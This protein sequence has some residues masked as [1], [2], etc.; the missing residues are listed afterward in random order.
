MSILRPVVYDGFAQRQLA[1]GDIL[2]GGETI[3]ATVVT[4]AITVTGAQLQQGIILRNPAAA[5]TD[6]LD[7]AANIIA[8]LS[9]GLGLGAIPNGLT[10]RVRWIVT[11]AQATTVQATANTGVTV[12]RGSIAASSAKEFLFTIVNGTPAQTFQCTTVN[13][14]NVLSGLTATQCSLLSVGMVIT[15]AVAGLQGQTIIAINGAAGTVTLSGNA[16]A[17]NSSPVTV[18]FSPVVQLDGLQ[19]GGI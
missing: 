12:N 4:T 7:T 1:Q 8:A 3:P 11:T 13:A 10:W 2:G 18:A 14:N 19:Q 15:N 16:N 6:T 5:A 9:V 17:T